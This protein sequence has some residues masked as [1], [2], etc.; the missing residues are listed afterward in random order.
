MRHEQYRGY[1]IFYDPP[2]I[3]TRAHD[4]QF[5]HEDWDLDDTRHGTAPTL[6]DAK[7]LI[8]EIE[9]DLFCEA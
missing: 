5:W 8:D 7:Q 2:P 4:Y 1:N 6:S 3:P 9:E